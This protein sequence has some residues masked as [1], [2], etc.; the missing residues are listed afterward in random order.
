MSAKEP[1]SGGAGAPYRSVK[2]GDRLGEPGGDATIDAH[3]LD[4]QLAGRFS[5]EVLAETRDANDDSDLLAAAESDDSDEID[6][7]LVTGMGGG[8]DPISDGVEV[9]GDLEE[10]GE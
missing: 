6:P 2:T 4:R 9:P 3:D 8:D 1:Q 5:R 7:N 10:L